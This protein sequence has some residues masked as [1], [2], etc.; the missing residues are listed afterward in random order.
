VA[1]ASCPIALP[2]GVCGL[3]VVPA[4]CPR[5]LVV[6]PKCL[7]QTKKK[8]PTKNTNEQGVSL[9]DRVGVYTR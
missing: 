3:Y 5:V 2:Y 9:Y 1:M 4:S 6:K 8:S 7:K